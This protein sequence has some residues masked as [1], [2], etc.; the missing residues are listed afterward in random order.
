MVARTI[1]SWQA[2]AL[3]EAFERGHEALVDLVGSCTATQWQAPC[4]AEGWSVGVTVHHLASDYA[5]TCRLVEAI[6]AGQSLAPFALDQKDEANRRHA[7]AHADCQVAATLAL[8]R[9]QG[10]A[11][12][13]FIRMISDA[14]LDRAVDLFG[15]PVSAR[16]VVEGGLIGHIDDHLASLRLAL[17]SGPLAQ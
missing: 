11:A 13:A 1:T 2:L 12:A 6:I 4:A 9:R 10:A 17:A 3:A 5:E 15:G 8:L 16:Q 14:D 7:L